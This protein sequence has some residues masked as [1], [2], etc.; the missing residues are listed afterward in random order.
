[1]LF[2][3]HHYVGFAVLGREFDWLN[4]LC[5]FKIHSFASNSKEMLFT[6]YIA[7]SNTYWYV[8]VT[9][10]AL[11]VSSREN[12]VYKDKGANNLSTQ[13]ISFGVSRSHDIGPTTISIVDALLEAL[14]DSSTANCSKALHDHVEY[15]P[16][17]GKLAS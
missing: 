9:S 14:H 12:S 16:V 13:S 3:V 4:F 1:V 2:P 11:S 15:S 17:Q 6:M 5:Y 8:G 10:I 7:K